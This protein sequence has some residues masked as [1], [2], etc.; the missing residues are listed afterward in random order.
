MNFGDFVEKYSIQ[1]ALPS[2]WISTG[3]GMGAMLNQM[4]LPVMQAFGGQM[5]RLFLGL[6]SAHAPASGRNQDLYD[7]IADYLGDKVYLNTR[8][9]DSKRTDDGVEVTVRN[10]IDGTETTFHAKKLLVAIQPVAEKLAAFDLDEV[11]KQ[12]FEKF[13]YTREYTGIVSSPSIPANTSVNNLPYSENDNNFLDWQDFNFTA[14]F[15]ALDYHK[16]LFHIIMVGDEKLGPKEAKAMTEQSFLNLV[17]SGVFAASTA[18]NTKLEWV[19]FSNHGPMHDR[20][21]KEDLEAGFVQ[22]LYALQGQRSTWYTGGAWASNYQTI[23]WEY[24][25]V[26]LPK[27]LAA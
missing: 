24:N 6:Q 5:A 21:S 9:I 18:N 20:V 27:M 17:A 25:E 3:L 14:I 2:I 12:L 1:A 10:E 7:A 22:S 15:E 13:Q 8:A 11:E 26:L 19:A 23:L 4:T 16:D